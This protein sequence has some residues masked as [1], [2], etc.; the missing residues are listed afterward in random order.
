MRSSSGVRHEPDER[1]ALERAAVVDHE[2]DPPDLAGLGV[3][4]GYHP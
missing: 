1:H 4:G 3:P 2:L